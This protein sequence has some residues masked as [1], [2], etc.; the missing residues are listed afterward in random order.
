M[1]KLMFGALFGKGYIQYWLRIEVTLLS[2]I[3]T[4]KGHMQ[5]YN[6]HE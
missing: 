2:L 3:I 4:S 1:F 6:L 5:W